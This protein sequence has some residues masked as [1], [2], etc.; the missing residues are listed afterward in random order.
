MEIKK[1]IDFANKIKI[2]FAATCD[3]EQPRVRPLLMWFADETGF[4][5][6]S[7]TVKNFYKQLLK[8]PKIELCFWDPDEGKT[9]RV[10]GEVEFLEDLE[11]KKRC[12]KERPFLYEI[13]IRDEKDPILALFRVSQGEAFFWTRA[14]SM[15]EDQIQ[16]IKF[17]L[18]KQT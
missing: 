10:T 8:N 9:L 4:Y 6:Q 16:K 15:K 2:C 3:G 18:T 11:L 14:D 1:C 12:L 17:G 7:Q 5:F 13:G